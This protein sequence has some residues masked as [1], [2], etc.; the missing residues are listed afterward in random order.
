MKSYVSVLFRSFRVSAHPVL[1]V[2]VIACPE[3]GR[4]D[5]VQL[6]IREPGARR[7]RSLNLSRLRTVFLAEKQIEMYFLPAPVWTRY[8][9]G[10]GL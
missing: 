6:L 10:G 4:M 3:F 5:E 2:V 1:D 8:T 9:R 7:Q